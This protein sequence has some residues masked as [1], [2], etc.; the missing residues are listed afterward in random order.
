[1]KVRLRARSAKPIE[2][3]PVALTH[4]DEEW[5]LVDAITASHIPRSQW[6]DINITGLLFNAG[7]ITARH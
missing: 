6:G 3:H 5:C 2:V 7:G 4:D 1:L